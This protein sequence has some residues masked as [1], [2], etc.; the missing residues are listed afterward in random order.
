MPRLSLVCIT[1]S[2]NPFVIEVAYQGQDLKKKKCATKS[3]KC[4]ILFNKCIDL[5]HTYQASTKYMYGRVTFKSYVKAAH[6]H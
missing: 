3:Q 5:N 6:V 2:L 4:I 1:F